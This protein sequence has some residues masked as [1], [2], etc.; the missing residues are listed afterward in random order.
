MQKVSAIVSSGTYTTTYQVPAQGEIAG[1]RVYGTV[2][3]TGVGQTHLARMLS[4]PS[5]GNWEKLAKR[6]K[7]KPTENYFL[8]EYL[9]DHPSPANKEKNARLKGCFQRLGGLGILVAMTIFVLSCPVMGLLT[10]FGTD[11]QGLSE[12]LS[13]I[14][15][16]IIA[17]VVISPVLL[18]IGGLIYQVSNSREYKEEY[19]QWSIACRKYARQIIPN[20][21]RNVEHNFN[22]LY[23]CYRDD[24]VFLPGTDFSCRAS[25]MQ[26]MS[27]WL[28]LGQ[29]G[30]DAL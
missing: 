16:I 30:S 3:Q 15:I 26:S 22:M 11:E 18:G 2:S 24:L 25:D 19:K 14:T 17:L 10:W 12:V 4:K 20:L 9:K 1:H 29:I 23:Y 8:Q 13:I 21:R 27:I 7:D 28:V 6:W 5:E